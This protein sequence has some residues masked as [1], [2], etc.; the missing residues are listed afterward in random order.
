[1]RASLFR[2]SGRLTHAPDRADPSPRR[3]ITCAY[4]ELGGARLTRRRPPRQPLDAIAGCSEARPEHGPSLPARGPAHALQ[5]TLQAALNVM[6][7]DGVVG[8]Y[9]GLTSSLLGIAVTNGYVH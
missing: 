8:L 1:M 6:K 3:A 9:D 4:P 5:S 7:E 2:H